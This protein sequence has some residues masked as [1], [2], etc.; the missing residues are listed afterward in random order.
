MAEFNLLQALLDT[1]FVPEKDVPM[2][3]FGHD[4]VFR[5]K[6]L[7]E[8]VRKRL[9]E[10]ATYPV[11]GGEML[12]Q[13]KFNLSLIAATCVTPDWNDP[14]LLEGLGVSTAIEAVDKRLLPGERLKL[15][16]AVR[17]LSGF[18]TEMDDLKN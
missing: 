9:V 2:K 1:E 6:A 7:D 11:K 13:E 10:Q 8:K 16:E 14:R 5:V 15:I 18:D 4:A 3:R 17:E 12:D